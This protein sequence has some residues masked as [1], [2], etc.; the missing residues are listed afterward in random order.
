MGLWGRFVPGGGP[1][2]G[3][4]MLAV[5]M[6][7]AVLVVLVA[8][9]LTLAPTGSDGITDESADDGEFDVVDSGL[10]QAVFVESNDTL[11]PA[12]DPEF[13][14]P[15][16]NGPP[17]IDTGT[18]A[19]LLASEPFTDEQVVQIQS[20]LTS[21]GYRGMGGD[22][23]AL[24]PVASETET[25]VLVR[26]GNLEPRD[27]GDA[28]EPFVENATA[29]Q[30]LEL[31]FERTTLPETP[32]NAT[33]AHVGDWTLAAH[34]NR[35][36]DRVHYQLGSYD[37]DAGWQTTGTEEDLQVNV[38][39]ETVNGA[40]VAGGLEF[41]PGDAPVD[42]WVVD[43]NRSN[44]DAVSTH[45]GFN[46]VAVGADEDDLNTDT[47]SA[48]T[49]WQEVVTR[50]VFN[51][52]YLDATTTLDT[53]LA[54]DAEYTYFEYAA[55]GAE[56]FLV[57]ASLAVETESRDGLTGQLPA[58]DVWLPDYS[59]EPVNYTIDVAGTYSNGTEVDLSG[60]A[61]VSIRNRTASGLEDCADGQG[62]VSVYDDSEGA[63]FYN[64]L[65]IPHTLTDLQVQAEMEDVD[66]V[67]D[68]LRKN[69]TVVDPYES[70]S[71]TLT[72]DSLA[73]GNDMGALEMQLH[74]RKQGLGPRVVPAPDISH[75]DSAPARHAAEGLQHGLDLRLGP[76]GRNVRQVADALLGIRSLDVDKREE[77]LDATPTE[78]ASM[79]DASGTGPDKMMAFFDAEAT[80][81]AS[82]S[83][84]NCANYTT[85]HAV[86]GPEHWVGSTILYTGPPSQLGLVY[87]GDSQ[88]DVSA[89]QQVHRVQQTTT[90]IGDGIPEYRLYDLATDND[91]LTD[92]EMATALTN[93][94]G[95]GGDPIWNE[96]AHLVFQ[97]IELL[98]KETPEPLYESTQ[99]QL[100]EGADA[101]GEEVD[102][103]PGPSGFDDRVIDIVETLADSSTAQ[104]A[105]TADEYP[106][107]NATQQRIYLW[108]GG[109]DD[110]QTRH[111]LREMVAFGNETQ[112]AVERSADMLFD[113]A[114]YTLLDQQALDQGSVELAELDE[115]AARW[116]VTMDATYT[117]YGFANYSATDAV[118]IRDPGS[119]IVDIN[120]TLETVN[121]EPLL[122]KVNV[123]S[124]HSNDIIQTNQS[125]EI[126]TTVTFRN[127]ET[128]TNPHYINYTLL[129]PDFDV[130]PCITGGG[131][132]DRCY[133]ADGYSGPTTPD[134]FATVDGLQHTVLP[135][136]E[137]GAT[138]FGV[139]DGNVSTPI[140]NETGP[141][142]LQATH[143]GSPVTDSVA[144][145]VVDLRVDGQLQPDTEATDPLDYWV[146]KS[147]APDGTVYPQKAPVGYEV[148]YELGHIAADLGFANSG[149]TSAYTG[150]YETE[151]ESEEDAYLDSVATRTYSDDAPSSSFPT[152]QTVSLTVTDSAGDTVTVS[153]PVIL[154]PGG[155]RYAAFTANP[156]QPQTG[157][158]VTFDA[159]H[160][161]L[162]DTVEQSAEYQW[163]F[164]S[165]TN[166]TTT[167]PAVSHAYN[168]SGTYTVNLTIVSN[169]SDYSTFRTVS[170][171]ESAGELSVGLTADPGAVIQ[172]PDWETDAQLG[173]RL[174][175]ATFGAGD[176]QG[177]IVDYTWELGND[178]TVTT[179]TPTVNHTFYVG[180]APVSYASSI[181][182]FGG[183][184]GFT[185][186]VG[187]S[188]GGGAVRVGFSETEALDLPN[189]EKNLS[190]LHHYNVD[191]GGSGGTGDPP[192]PP[193]GTFNI[194]GS[195]Y[196]DPL[197]GTLDG[198]GTVYPWT[199]WVNEDWSYNKTVPKNETRGYYGNILDDDWPNI[200]NINA[201]ENQSVEYNIWT[202]AG[203]M[204]ASRGTAGKAALANGDVSWRN[205]TG[206]E[207]ASCV[208]VPNGITDHINDPSVD[209]ASKAQNA[210]ASNT[211]LNVGVGG[212]HEGPGP[213]S[214]NITFQLE[215]SNSI[216]PPEPVK[217]TVTFKGEHEE[218]GSTTLDVKFE[219]T[220]K[221]NEG[222]PD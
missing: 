168:A 215:D 69:L 171:T 3:N 91:T 109:V 170:V 123:P 102:S 150:N 80:C 114:D 132:F 78:R 51:T 187:E 195:K 126:T 61:N 107:L 9:G 14:P 64:Y 15:D 149:V 161:N 13:H 209:W 178:T 42:V 222:G 70:Q 75:L 24:E 141:L 20:L 94:I 135:Q 59:L 108:K 60:P 133:P 196:Q 213:H 49:D 74:P 44:G 166:R 2:R 136:R 39:E 145:S 153:R 105:Y 137:T 116:N 125:A 181:Q 220:P 142:V 22:I 111:D 164:G 90:R 17:P 46:L 129:G 48:E 45:G 191:D 104:T 106:S 54:V 130:G 8:L 152:K 175:T 203:A 16:S 219:V 179:S 68:T 12:Y 31:V 193:A 93:A 19:E 140:V 183:D 79:V 200:F 30:D 214:I 172:S 194:L 43:T 87:R 146:N 35:S 120:T 18:V 202:N 176:P 206:C 192:E 62:C 158:Q 28:E 115:L 53:R 154:A 112:P 211:V 34:Q 189:V 121:L 182:E 96:T 221:D 71:L 66:G 208:S 157:E 67:T 197:S 174:Q 188:Y 84:V 95:Y 81:G 21:L 118:G 77:F 147:D 25:G 41:D 65:V 76:G 7:L 180:P 151:I 82:T 56:P 1:G 162:P 92:P 216:T 205:S 97:Y 207:N 117:E 33:T 143:P 212:K 26:L 47:L 98:G 86:T 184:N 11:D 63:L 4:V 190:D 23:A 29:V 5:A 210:Q 124:L 122:N 40:P 72:N 204:D 218:F 186:N 169:G 83:S 36:T 52:T 110:S 50:P 57:D 101:I 10:Q 144:A 148:H 32:E 127:G 139:R 85:A 37:P 27:L 177:D 100:K 167:T 89:F 163:E 6:M 99:W 217:G 138:Q 165:G 113:I 185:L 128:E 159:S 156:S 134:G 198:P 131:T 160:S 201:T 119:N 73:V 173:P 88:V 58:G 103:V 55:S 155:T 38:H 199:T